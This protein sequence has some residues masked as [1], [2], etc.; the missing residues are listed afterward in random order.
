MSDR[1]VAWDIGGA[2]L[3]AALAEAGQLCAVQQQP[4]PLWQDEIYLQTGIDQILNLWPDVNQHRITM[5][6]ELADLFVDRRSG[7]TA[8]VQT[9][10]EALGAKLD[11]PSVCLWAG[12]K[13]FVAASD[14][15]RYWQHIASANWRASA[16]WLAQQHQ[17]AV[18]ID[19]GSTTTDIIICKHGKVA[20]DSI[21]DRDRLRRD[22]LVYTGVVRTPLCALA[23]RAPLHGEWHSLAAEVF[24]TAADIYRIL[25]WLPA[26]ADQLPSADGRSKTK[27]DSTARLARM[28]GCD[29]HDADVEQWRHVAAVLARRQINTLTQALDRVV[30]RDVLDQDA[31]LVGAGVGRFLVQRLAQTLERPYLDFAELCSCD[32]D[33]AGLASDC[34]PAVALALLGANR[35]G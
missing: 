30:S 12:V 13:G 24:A 1:I 16:G 5:T 14:A 27:A 33:L 29:S 6:G 21:T 2:H 22:E 10:T 28:L 26:H 25:G 35:C 9:L 11:Q 7:V 19:I 23:E 8:I 32:A 17:Q 4:C 15:Q 31:P 3:K 34:A 18:L 20:T